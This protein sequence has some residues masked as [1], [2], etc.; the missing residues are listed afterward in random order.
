MK[1]RCGAPVTSPAR[2]SSASASAALSS[3]TSA[4]VATSLSDT[5]C[6]PR[7]AS[8]RA[9]GPPALGSRSR[10]RSTDARTVSG[11]SDAT[12]SAL[13]SVGSIP[14]ARTSLTSCSSRNGLPPV[15]WWQAA[16]KAGSD[17]PSSAS[18]RRSAPPCERGPGRIC[19]VAGSARISARGTPSCPTSA[20]RAASS[21][22][23]GRSA[24]RRLRKRS[25]AIDA[26]SAH[27]ASSMVIRSGRSRA[28]FAVSQYSPCR[29]WYMSSG[30]SASSSAAGV[31]DRQCELRG[32]REEGGSLLLGLVERHRVR[33]LAH[34]A[35]RIA[36]LELRG[37]DRHR[38]HVARPRQLQAGRDQAGLAY[39]G[40]TLDRDDA[41]APLD[42]G[43]ERLVEGL[44]LSVAFE[45]VWVHG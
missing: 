25:A 28:R 35:V 34:D 24:M 33:R 12:R 4:S 13:A 38:V 17:D 2:S 5:S 21:S 16:A 8:A 45:Q 31:E 42:G 7:I 18:M 44:K 40:R 27:W 43:G 22:T 3:G 29:R 30:L 1:R 39:S 10:R 36:P 41:P 32:S 15:A 19:T 20:V 6:S 23:I 14:S 9:T 11:P 37:T 26:S